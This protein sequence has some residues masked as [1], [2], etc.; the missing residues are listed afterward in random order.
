[1]KLFAFENDV[2]MYSSPAVDQKD[3]YKKKQAG[4]KF[5]RAG[6][7]LAET[8]IRKTNS[9]L[10]NYRLTYALCLTIFMT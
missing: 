1:M 8:V 7:N 2:L 5:L 3:V 10:F 4:V 6:Q 9:G